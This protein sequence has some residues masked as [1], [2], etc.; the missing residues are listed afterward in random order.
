MSALALSHL[1]QDAQLAILPGA[2]GEAVGEI[3]LM[4]ADMHGLC[5]VTPAGATKKA[6]LGRS[7][8]KAGP[9]L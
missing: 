6:I 8:D 9:K 4:Q 5:D 2:H 3:C 1:L 7:D